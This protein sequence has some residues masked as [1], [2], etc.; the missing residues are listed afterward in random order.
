MTNNKDIN[1]W[2]QVVVEPASPLEDVVTGEAEAARTFEG[3]FFSVSAELN[4]I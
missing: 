4:G 3:G 2:M 1:I